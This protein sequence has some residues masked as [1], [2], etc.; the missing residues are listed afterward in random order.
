MKRVVQILDALGLAHVCVDSDQEL[1]PSLPH[2]GGPA[3]DANLGLHARY[4]VK[5][6]TGQP[7][8]AWAA[9]Y[10]VGP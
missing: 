8:A 5:T 9:R 2:G 1:W 10:S 3:S 4:C 6:G 7:M